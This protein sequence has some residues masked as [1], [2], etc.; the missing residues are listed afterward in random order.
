MSET[1]FVRKTSRDTLLLSAGTLERAAGGFKPSRL[2]TTSEYDYQFG[3]EKRRS[4]L[5]P[6]FP[7]PTAGDDF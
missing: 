7:Q 1:P 5:V 3:D 4:G 2:G 6:V